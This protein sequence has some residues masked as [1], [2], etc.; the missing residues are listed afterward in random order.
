[1]AN[2]PINATSSIPS[3]CQAQHRFLRLLRAPQRVFGVPFSLKLEGRDNVSEVDDDRGD[4]VA[5][6]A[7]EVAPTQRGL[8][9]QVAARVE[10]GQPPG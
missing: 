1:M 7:L 5:V 8:G 10:R 3:A 2:L 6:V 9:D 4:V